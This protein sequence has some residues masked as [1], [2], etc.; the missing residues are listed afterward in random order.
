MISNG[1]SSPLCVCVCVCVLWSYACSP[2]LIS[3]T[4]SLFL[5]YFPTTCHKAATYWACFQSFIP[6]D[7]FN[8]SKITFWEIRFVPRIPECVRLYSQSNGSFPRHLTRAFSQFPVGS[9]SQYQTDSL[10]LFFCH[11]FQRRLNAISRVTVKLNACF[12]M[13]KKHEAAAATH[14]APV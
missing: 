4:T 1:V 11:V 14:H 13:I 9:W 2:V 6:P 3:R 7:V 10:F 12:K 8:I 5:Q